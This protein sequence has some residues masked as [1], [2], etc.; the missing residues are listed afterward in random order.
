MPTSRQ[1]PIVL[2][3]AMAA[4]LLLAVSALSY[5]G[6]TDAA[7]DRLIV[8]L[9][10][11]VPDDAAELTFAGLGAEVVDFIPQVRTYVLKVRP[12]ERNALR[13]EL[14]HSSLIKSVSEDHYRRLQS[15]TPN[16]YWYP[17]EWH[18]QKIQAPAAWS[19]TVGSS[20]VVI[21]IVDS[22]VSAVPDLAAKLLPGADLIDGGTD[23]SDGLNHGTA[24]AGIAGAITNNSIGVAGLAW[25][26]RILPVKVYTNSGTTTCSA[27][28]SGITWA[29]DH[30][31][32]VINMSFSGTSPCTGEQSA[33][34]YAWSK[35]A[36]LVAAA[37]NNSSSA[38]EYPAAYSNVLGVTA[39]LQD[40]S[41]DSFSDYGSWVKL[42]APGCNLY[43]TYN[44][45][46]YAG[47]CG[48]SAA[49]PVVAGVAGLVMA[50]NPALSNAQVASLI[51]QNADDLGAPGFDNYFGWG[52]VAAYRA[53][54]A[55]AGAAP[56][57]D[58]TPP[59]AAISSPANGA[60]VAGTITVD[61]TASDNVGVAQVALY[62][63]GS[64]IG[65]DTTAPY[66]F[67]WD[68]TASAAGA[69]TLQAIAYDA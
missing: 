69:H 42:S 2:C 40:D 45:G 62:L 67:A 10:G 22:G 1:F 39:T 38:P 26:N 59:S 31:A 4:A 14:S 25:L 50:A 53:V 6:N 48:T 44:S 68:T 21:A 19:L 32:R 8:Q 33:I 15:V 36:V 57:P 7:P 9:R 13:R 51:E 27:I 64:P 23:T 3:A 63:D 58:T 55:A 56:P 28:A 16:D 17:G 34:D 29:A 61:V 30:G 18:L 24:L 47:A 12:E 11:G 41:I 46:S 54:A 60:T 66:S 65:T 5:A 43:T 49:A 52:R 20:S 37:G 35:G